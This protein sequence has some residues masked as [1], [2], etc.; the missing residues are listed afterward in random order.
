MD[1]SDKESV[2]LIAEWCPG[3]NTLL[4]A[5]TPLSPSSKPKPNMD[6]NVYTR[7]AKGRKIY[8]NFP[9]GV[10]ALGILGILLKFIKKS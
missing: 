3:Q 7:V 4:D 5:N 8:G 6:V 2:V 1:V 9:W 10:K